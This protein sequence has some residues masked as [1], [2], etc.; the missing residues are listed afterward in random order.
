M[1]M[2]VDVQRFHSALQLNAVCELL[3]GFVKN[4]EKEEDMLK[5]EE[6]QS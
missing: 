1:D 6:A 5:C 3:V 2:G 4:V